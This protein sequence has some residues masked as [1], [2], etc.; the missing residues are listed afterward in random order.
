MSTDTNEDKP[1]EAGQAV[2]LRPYHFRPD[3]I[4]YYTGARVTVVEQ[5]GAEV[6]VRMPNGMVA[7]VSRKEVQR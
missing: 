2:T 1:L 5:R 4:A 6:Q 7:M 3:A